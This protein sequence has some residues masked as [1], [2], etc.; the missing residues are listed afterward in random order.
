MNSGEVGDLLPPE[1]AAGGNGL[2]EDAPLQ[3]SQACHRSREVHV[4]GR[5]TRD[6]SWKYLA[7]IVCICDK[8]GISSRRGRFATQTSNVL[9]IA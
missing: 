2:I 7:V 9:G 5:Y 3:S 8:S 4:H 1:A 6:S